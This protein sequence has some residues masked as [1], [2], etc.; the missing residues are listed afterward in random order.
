M[1]D[2]MHGLV[3]E[4][5]I[6]LR[7]AIDELL[8]ET[9]PHTPL[10]HSKTFKLLDEGTDRQIVWPA[11]PD[12]WD[13]IQVCYFDKYS[14]FYLG[15]TDYDYKAKLICKLCNYDSQ[16][17]LKLIRRLEAAI[18]WCKKR[19]EGRKRAAEE[20][21]KQQKKAVDTLTALAVAYKLSKKHKCL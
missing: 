19:T 14:T 20:I 5:L 13:E 16:K 2:E 18:E 15:Y 8:E 7:K 3:R 12:R 1:L 9:I 10:P 4:K 11:Y 21:L 6:E 17:V